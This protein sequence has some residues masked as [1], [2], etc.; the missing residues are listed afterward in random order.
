MEMQIKSRKLGRT[1]TFS[2]PGTSYIYV[3]LNGQSGTLGNQICRGGATMGSTLSY[4]GDGQEE[5]EKI[6]KKW[7]KA[8]LKKDID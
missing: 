4:E 3:D 6:C 1:L 8:Y 5:F 7:Y 2:R